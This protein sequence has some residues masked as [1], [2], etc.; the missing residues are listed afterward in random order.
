MPK[1]KQ[2]EHHP[3]HPWIITLLAFS[4][5]GMVIVFSIFL[6]DILQEPEVQIVEIPQKLD[7]VEQDVEIPVEEEPVE[8]II[9][10]Q[11]RTAS[12]V[13]INPDGINRHITF[14]YPYEWNIATDAY[15]L[16]SCAFLDPNEI[17]FIDES[18][19]PMSGTIELC[20]IHGEAKFPYDVGIR[21]DLSITDLTL[22]GL[23]AKYTSVNSLDK[24][25]TTEYII[26][27]SDSEYLSINYTHNESENIE[28]TEAWELIK[29]TINLK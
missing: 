28:N 18:S 14:Q 7:T 23:S 21:E 19:P 3:E 20:I 1:S 24:A 9:E 15:S 4:T 5:V 12:M 26:A 2:T 25:I 29:S 27:Q 13:Y 6:Y 8:E 11:E 16:S 22:S 17:E 10:N